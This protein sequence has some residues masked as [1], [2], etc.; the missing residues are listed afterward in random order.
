MS[1]LADEKTDLLDKMNKA[2]QSNQDDMENVRQTFIDKTSLRL[3]S[4]KDKMSNSINFEDVKEV[5]G[6]PYRKE[7]RVDSRFTDLHIKRNNQ[8]VKVIKNSASRG[9]LDL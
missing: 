2:K 8:T 7:T 1:K 5:L 9:N 4:I 6:S 3:T